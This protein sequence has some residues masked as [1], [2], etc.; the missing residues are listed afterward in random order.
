[1][2]GRVKKKKKT[3]IYVDE[4]VWASDT[5]VWADLPNEV[6]GEEKDQVTL[7]ELEEEE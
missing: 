4:D 5:V 6:I 7:E 2:S 3:R 1:M